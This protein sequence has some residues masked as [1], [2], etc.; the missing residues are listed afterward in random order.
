M[1][2]FTN[3]QIIYDSGL[4]DQEYDNAVGSGRRIVNS[5]RS[6]RGRRAVNR[7][8]SGI[9]R[10]GGRSTGRK[11]K[12]LNRAIGVIPVVAGARYL[13]RRKA[14]R[15]E[16]ERQSQPSSSSARMPSRSRTE[17]GQYQGRQSAP[18]PN[19]PAKPRKPFQSEGKPNTQQGSVSTAIANT[20]P[21]PT[22]NNKI[23]LIVGGVLILGIAAYMYSKRKKQ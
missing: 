15:E 5:S 21:A 16:S 19:R 23:A 2:V 10:E 3:N 14:Q 8:R 22:N 1:D 20:P 17:A 13:Q 7:S 6:S 4:E 12:G 11:R 9:G 18:K